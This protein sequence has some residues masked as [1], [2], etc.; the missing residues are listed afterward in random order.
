MSNIVAINARLEVNGVV[1]SAHVKDINQVLGLEMQD[2]TGFGATV[3]SSLPGLQTVQL[4]AN[5]MQSFAAGQ[6]DAT[7]YPLW[8]GR[9]AHAVNVRG[10]AGVVSATN[11]EMRFSALF[12]SELGRPMAV[13]ELMMVA[14]TWVAAKGCTIVRA[15]A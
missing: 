6:V 5:V 4:S 11:P 2:D 15:V 8:A 13:G 12:I 1:L 3:R 10:D 14:V 9:T 7:L